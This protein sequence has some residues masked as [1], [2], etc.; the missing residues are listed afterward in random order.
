MRTTPYR[1]PKAPRAPPG[2]NPAAEGLKAA[3]EHLEECIKW[4]S[5][6]SSQLET[7]KHRLR[8]R[9]DVNSAP[10]TTALARNLAT[11]LSSAETRVCA[12]IG[13]HATLCVD[14]ARE[15][16]F[17]HQADFLSFEENLQTHG[18]YYHPS[19]AVLPTPSS[20][21]TAAEPT[22]DS[23]QTKLLSMHNTSMALLRELL[24]DEF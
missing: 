5:D 17:K 19:R 21:P 7:K 8:H 2:I 18:S 13:N 1:I 16:V 23:F 12:E 14:A 9:L 22:V 20:P 15:R 6:I 11:I 4:K 24:D 10:E 3:K